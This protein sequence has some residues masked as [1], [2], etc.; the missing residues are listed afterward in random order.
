MNDLTNEIVTIAV[1]R[2][3]AIEFLTFFPLPPGTVRI[4]VGYEKGPVESSI[5]IDYRCRSYSDHT[6]YIDCRRP[7]GPAGPYYYLNDERLYLSDYT[8]YEQPSR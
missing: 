4:D 3:K 2:S 1:L 8:T 7:P 5:R 6:V